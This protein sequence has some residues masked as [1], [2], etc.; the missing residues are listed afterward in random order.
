MEPLFGRKAEVCGE[1]F[2]T[3]KIWRYLE[4]LGYIPL[5][6]VKCLLYLLSSKMR[7]YWSWPFILWCYNFTCLNICMGFPG[8]AAVNN[9]PANA[10]DTNDVDSIPGRISW[11][12]RWQPTPGFLPGIFHMQWSLV[13]Y[14][15]WG[16]RVGH[17][18]ACTRT[19]KHMQINS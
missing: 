16:H 19:C 5:E 7:R 13:G 9:P 3:V 2:P 12:R 4:V 18:W 8:V 6:N 11:S 10:G 1:S 17:N 14:S 15:P